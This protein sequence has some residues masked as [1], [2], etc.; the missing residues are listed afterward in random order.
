MTET[1]EE[2]IEQL[3]KIIGKIEESYRFLS[4]D[5]RRRQY[6][7]SIIE[8]PKRAFSA[9]LLSQ[10]TRTYLLRGDKKQ[11]RYYIE[12]ACDLAPGNAEYKQLLRD[13]GG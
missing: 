8:P 5:D 2:R 3:K 1:Y 11:A 10:H 7:D 6:R 9:E 4:D 13:S 12:M